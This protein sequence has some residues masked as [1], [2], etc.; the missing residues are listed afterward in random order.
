MDVEGNT[1]A[2]GKEELLGGVQKDRNRERL[3]TDSEL[4]SIEQRRGTWRPLVLALLRP[5]HVAFSCSIGP[6]HAALSLHMLDPVGSGRISL[7]T[8]SSST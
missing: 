2:N 7:T 4:E 5:C 6:K 8:Q 1:E 3:F